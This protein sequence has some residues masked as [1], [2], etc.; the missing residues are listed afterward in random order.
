M[1]FA[2]HIV[3]EANII[4]YTKILKWHKL[5]RIYVNFDIADCNEN[6]NHLTTLNN[7]TS[8]VIQK[9]RSIKPFK[10]FM[11]ALL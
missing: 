8:G 1:E 9:K 6:R 7:I 3:P 11:E 10:I 4:R 5:I 2:E